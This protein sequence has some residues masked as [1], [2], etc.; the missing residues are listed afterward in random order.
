VL[1]FSGPPLVQARPPG[2]RHSLAYL[3]FRATGEKPLKR[4]GAV[5]MEEEEAEGGQRSM[6]M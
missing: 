1:W 6:V 4:G 3:H 2:L 5:A